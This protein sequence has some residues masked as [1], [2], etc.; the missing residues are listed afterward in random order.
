MTG[1]T[2]LGGSGTA[3]NKMNPALIVNKI[4]YAGV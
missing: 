3:V 1:T 4:I 2:P